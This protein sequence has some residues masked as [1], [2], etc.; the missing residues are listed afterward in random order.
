MSA[1]ITKLEQ[2]NAKITREARN[3]K[4]LTVASRRQALAGVGVG[5]VAA[6]LTALSLS[7]LAHGVEVITHAPAWHCW[8]MAGGIDLGFIAAEISQLAC[9]PKITKQVAKFARPAILGTLAGSAIMNALAFAVQATSIPAM[10]GAVVLGVAIP[11][12][13]YA[14]ARIGAAIWLDTKAGQ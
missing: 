7:H 8:S 2:T 13:I 10:C 6:S 3:K 9:S 14:L 4:R 12:L 1:T 11:A 5:A